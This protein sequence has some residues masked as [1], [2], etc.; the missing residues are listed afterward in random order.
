MKKKVIDDEYSVKTYIKVP[1][2]VY[3][4]KTKRIRKIKTLEGTMIASPGDYIITD[5]NGEKY[6]CKPDI[7]HKTYV[8]F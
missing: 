6:P 5:I 7:F 2:L 1:R 4:Y 3:V 8:R